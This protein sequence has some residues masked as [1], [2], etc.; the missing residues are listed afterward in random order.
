MTLLPAPPPPPVSPWWSRDGPIV[1]LIAGFFATLQMVWVSVNVW[2]SRWLSYNEH[3][4]TKGAVAN[5]TALT[6]DGIAASRSAETA[7]NSVNA[8]IAGTLDA[9]QVQ[10]RQVQALQD[11]RGRDRRDGDST[12]TTF[13][14]GEASGIEK[15]RTRAEEHE[16]HK[17]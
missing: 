10:Q 15:E 16:E 2:L 9:V 5:N 3:V 4:Q 8:K 17:P 7:A 11:D 13:A 14:K 1:A 12:E 6:I